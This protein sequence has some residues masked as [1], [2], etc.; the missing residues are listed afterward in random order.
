MSLGGTITETATFT[1]TVSAVQPGS[2]ILSS[3]VDGVA[4]AL[5]NRTRYLLEACTG[6]YLLTAAPSYANPALAL[7]TTELRWGSGGGTATTPGA[8]FPLQL[9]AGLKLTTVTMSL[10]GSGTRLSGGAPTLEVWKATKAGVTTQLGSTATD[11]TTVTFNSEHEISV[12][13]LTEVADPST[14]LYWVKVDIEE[15]V[16]TYTYSIRYTITTP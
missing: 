13:S 12:G 9:P 2:L 15:G 1:A 10:K 3:D 16:L 8:V 5:A 7:D 4:T 14:Y 11:N 6:T